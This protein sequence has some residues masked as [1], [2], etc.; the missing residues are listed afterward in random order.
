MLKWPKGLQ[1]AKYPIPNIRWQAHGPTGP[2]V[3]APAELRR[4]GGQTGIPTKD[5]RTWFL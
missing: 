5:D 1:V 2:P 3:F 4:A